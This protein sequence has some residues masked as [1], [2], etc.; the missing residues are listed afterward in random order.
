MLKDQVV[1]L[2]LKQTGFSEFITEHMHDL[3]VDQIARMD[4]LIK[5][6]FHFKLTKNKI[7][8]ADKIL[9]DL[10]KCYTH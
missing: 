4:P 7:A 3:T 5:R 8:E 2:T 6:L 1:A 10:R 9:R